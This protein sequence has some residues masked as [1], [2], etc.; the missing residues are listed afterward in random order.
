MS[1]DTYMYKIVY[2]KAGTE[3]MCHKQTFLLYMS[4]AFLL[5]VSRAEQ[6]E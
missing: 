1:K 2:A 5:K 6:N 3:W 4:T